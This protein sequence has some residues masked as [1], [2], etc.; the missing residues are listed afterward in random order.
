MI[1]GFKVNSI[2][3]IFLRPFGT[4]YSLDQVWLAAIA[5]AKMCIGQAGGDAS[6][7]SAVEKANLDEERLVD[8]FQRVRFFRQSGSQRVQAYWAASVF[9]NNREHQTAVN[10]IEAVPI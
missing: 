10:F 6:S 8:F 3:A 2:A 5:D 9:L 7:G 4:Q 1:S